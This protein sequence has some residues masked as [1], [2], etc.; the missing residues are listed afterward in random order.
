MIVALLQ[1]LLSRFQTAVDGIVVRDYDCSVSVRD[2]PF[3]DLFRG[4]CPVRPTGVRVSLQEDIVGAKG[5]VPGD[6]IGIIGDVISEGKCSEF[7]EIAWG[8]SHVFQLD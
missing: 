8:L 3:N 2:A 5:L 4:H 7:R 6:C 1:R